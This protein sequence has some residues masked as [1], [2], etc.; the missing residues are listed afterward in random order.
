MCGFLAPGLSSTH[1]HGGTGR[2][3]TPSLRRMP[4]AGT[5]KGNPDNKRNHR[6]S[7]ARGRG[8]PGSVAGA[9]RCTLEGRAVWVTPAS[10]LLCH[11]AQS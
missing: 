3:G 7:G 10:L 5:V 6:R 11:W 2:G 1:G 9:G 4:A 8:S